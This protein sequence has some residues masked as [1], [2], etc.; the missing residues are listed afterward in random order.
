MKQYHLISG[1][2]RSGTT[3]LST[4][5]KQNP[6]FEASISGPLARFVRAIIQESSAQGGYRFECPPEKRKKL[7]SGLFDNY[8]D[9]QTKEVAFNTNRGWSLLLPPIFELYPTAKMILCV[10]DIGWILDSF[11]ML[12]RKN[13]YIFTSMFSLDEG[14]NVYSRCQALL[15]PN[16]TLGFAYAAVKQALCSE[17]K[18][19]IMVLDYVQLATDPANTMK[20]VYHFINEPF[21]QHDFDDVAASYDEFDEEVQLPGLHTTRKKVQ[22]IER[23]SVVPPDIWHMCQGMEVWK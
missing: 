16:K 20:A 4:I 15:S 2:P 10:R 9:D 18:S 23:E 7:I 14:I 22:Y 17:Y 5:L 13:P 12:Q 8:Y 3:L 21:F 6:R 1:L 11:E 19:R